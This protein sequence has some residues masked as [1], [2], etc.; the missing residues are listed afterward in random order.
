M[1][2]SNSHTQQALTHIGKSPNN[3][4]P[5]KLTQMI[6]LITN[7]SKERTEI[8]KERRKLQEG[9]PR[10]MK[11]RSKARGPKHRIG[12]DQPTRP[13]QEEGKAEIVE[14]YK[15]RNCKT[16]KEMANYTRPKLRRS[17]SRKERAETRIE[18]LTLNARA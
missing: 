5:D 11:R 6:T 18:E 9:R 3:S 10:L 13:K 16:V 14:R 17:A 2:N 4:Y 7:S 12:E 1:H 15:G 8:K